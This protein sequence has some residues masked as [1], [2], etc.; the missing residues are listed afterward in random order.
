[1]RFNKFIIDNYKVSVDSLSHPD[2][3]GLYRIINTLSE[4]EQNDN[5]N[6]V[7]T[8]ECIFYTLVEL[9][10]IHNIEM[11]T[12][13]DAFSFF[14]I[15]KNKGEIKHGINSVWLSR[16]KLKNATSQEISGALIDLILHRDNWDDKTSYKALKL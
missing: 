4:I 2:A 14:N 11:N 9:F 10:E 6:Q 3:N 7:K 16:T 1:M 12:T 15:T 8:V 13:A 5:I